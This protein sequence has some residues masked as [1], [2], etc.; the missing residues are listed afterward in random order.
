MRRCS[1]LFTT[2]PRKCCV[3]FSLMRMF[4]YGMWIFSVFV[5]NIEYIRKYLAQGGEHIAGVITLG[6]RTE[7]VSDRSAIK[8][9]A[10]V[11]GGT[12]AVLPT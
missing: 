3:A 8:K 2:K 5:V 4:I 12:T 6:M 10:E 7:A 1:S 11:Y 9:D